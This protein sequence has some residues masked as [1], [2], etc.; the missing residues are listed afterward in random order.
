[1]TPQR[2]HTPTILLCLLAAFCEGIDLQVAG[3]AAPGISAEMHPAAALLGYFFSAST[4]G[5]LFGALLGGHLADR[6]GRKL[7]LVWS[8]GLFGVCS[9]LTMLA[10]DVDMLL[11][12]RL[13]TGLGL[14]GAYPNLLALASE[15][16]ADNRRNANT[17][18][19]YAGTPIG[20]ALVSLGSSM[21]AP[22]HWRWLFAF[23][24]IAP[25]LITPVMALY[26]RESPAFL[27]T[28]AQAPRHVAQRGSRLAQFTAILAEGRAPRTLVLWSCFVL[29]LIIQY[30]LL[31]W[32]PT[33]MIGDGLSKPQAGMAQLGFNVGG[34]IAAIGIGHLL[35]GRWRRVAV[36]TAFIALPLLMLAMARAPGEVVVMTALATA[37]GCAVLS[38]LAFLYATAPLCYPTT[39]RGTGVGAAVG[40][41]R[42]GSIIGPLIGGALVGM[43]H[44]PGRLLLDLLPIAVAA[45][46]GAIVLAAM[47]LRHNEEEATPTGET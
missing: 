47:N 37:I 27:Q 17:T 19:V 4:V 45:A 39:I 1:M 40:A 13:A 3:V 11:W 20:G 31:S 35:E 18:L 46:I 43:G 30:L 28:Q 9:L 10:R 21:I 42:I 38:A 25:L 12:M 14:G 33:M 7:V 29:T 2:S 41:G 24:G 15:A 23:G 22:E 34:A 8:V 44:A 16:S 26:L 32:L 5:L 36:Y 6:I